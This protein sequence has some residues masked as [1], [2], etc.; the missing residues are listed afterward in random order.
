MAARSG[1]QRQGGQARSSRVLRVRGIA[2]ITIVFLATSVGCKT[3][4]WVTLRPK[5]QPPILE[6]WNIVSPG[7][8]EPS[9]RTMQMLRRHDLVSRV[10]QPPN[11]ILADMSKV[12]AR[13]PTGENIYALAE[14][15]YLN[16]Q[17]RERSDANDALSLYATAVS[18]A[19]VYLFDGRFRG[20]SNPYDPQFR[21]ACD[22]YN[23]ALEGML[24]I[25]QERGDLI[26]RAKHE[27]A[28]GPAGLELSV[29]S[30]SR[31][32]E[33]ADF[34]R[35]EFATDYQ[36]VGLRN[37]FRQFG[38]GVPL[39]A[40]RRKQSDVSQREQYYPPNLTFPVTAFLRL[41]PQE[42]AGGRRRA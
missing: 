19:Y 20:L 7:P 32:W 33:L 5:E 38:L 10:E 41:L 37:H 21:G 39:V 13:E 6:R 15:A 16:A 24:R 26:E 4:R 1:S 2:I 27:V 8:I 31:S 30:A 17:R 23:G 28:V 35:F 9:D 29:V 18:H 34:R 11:V 3:S 25:M 14:V 42:S 36:V 12:A 22:V 40:I